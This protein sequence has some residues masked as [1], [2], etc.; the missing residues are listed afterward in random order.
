MRRARSKETHFFDWCLARA[1]AARHSAEQ[2]ALLAE[3]A[4]RDGGFRAALSALDP[5]EAHLHASYRLLFPLRELAADPALVSGEATPSY[6]LMGRPVAALLARHAPATQFVVAVRD[7]VR[8]AYSQYNMTRDPEGTP[9]QL[10]R[11]GFAQLGA[12]SFDDV[13]DEELAALRAAGI[14]PA[15]GSDDFQAYLDGVRWR[16]EGGYHGGH[17]WLLRGLYALQLGLFLEH[18]PPERFLIVD[19]DDLAQDAGAAMR[20][21]HRHLGIAEQALPAEELT[22]KNARAYKAVTEKEQ[23]LYEFFA[24]FTAQWKALCEKHR[25]NIK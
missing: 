5:R 17:S 15:T 20:R 7:P 13:V 4:L 8:R 12:R 24:P 3:W 21:V 25:W 19:L 6:L 18:F 10:Q 2:E 9:A 22:P 1:R 14:S 16:N 23:E 11:R